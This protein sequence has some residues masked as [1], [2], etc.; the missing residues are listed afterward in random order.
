MQRPVS[1]PP[2]HFRPA[3]QEH[4]PAGE[5]PRGGCPLGQQQHPDQQQ[6]HDNTPGDE[7]HVEAAGGAM[8]ASFN[9]AGTR[10]GAKI[11]SKYYDMLIC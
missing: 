7:E 4:R 10:A 3:V 2:R 6:Q 8:C 11:A 9:I 1:L 5:Q